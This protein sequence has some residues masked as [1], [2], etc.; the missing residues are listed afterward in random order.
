MA[1]SRRPS[2]ATTVSL[3][4][5]ISV[6]LFGGVLAAGYRLGVRGA[7]AD[8]SAAGAAGG[9]RASGFVATA[10]PAPLGPSTSAPPRTRQRFVALPEGELAGF[11]RDPA[12]DAKVLAD[13]T[14]RE[15]AEGLSLGGAAYR[16]GSVRLVVQAGSPGPALRAAAPGAKAPDVLAYYLSRLARTPRA[17]LPAPGQFTDAPPGPLGG[18]MVCAPLRAVG[19]APAGGE[20]VWSDST[21]LGDVGVLG[22]SDLTAV[23]TL[24]RDVRRLVEL[25]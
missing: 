8:T 10:A 12:G 17:S 20:C 13:S 15:R 25:R 21:T 9:A 18:R 24:A 16:K 2:L 11:A 7:S 5:L 3:G 19:R 14:A 6:V 1:A 4:L 22:I 23:A